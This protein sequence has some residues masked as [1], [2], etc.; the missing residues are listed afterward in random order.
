VQVG[1]VVRV[2]GAMKDGVFVASSV[3]VMGMPT[4]GMP[5]L[6]REAAPATQPK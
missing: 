3:A 5:R 2:E 6:P 4:G 1:D